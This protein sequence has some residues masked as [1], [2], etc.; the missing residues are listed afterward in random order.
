MCIRD[1]G[2]DHHNRCP[3]VGG[4]VRS[5]R[6]PAGR[7]SISVPP[8][9][10]PGLERFRARAGDPAFNTLWEA[11]AILVALRVWGGRFTHRA[12]GD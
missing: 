10:R 6:P 11:L 2:L 5:C 12:P 1:S 8:L 4:W 9:A 3:P 7:L